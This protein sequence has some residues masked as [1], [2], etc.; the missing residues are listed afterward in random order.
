M[1]DLDFLD[2]WGKLEGFRTA[3]RANRSCCGSRFAQVLHD[4]LLAALDL[5]A[6]TCREGAKVQR[7]LRT[8]TDPAVR[9]SLEQTLGDCMGD[10]ESGG[11]GFYPWHL[12]DAVDPDPD[13]GCYYHP[14]ASMWCH[15]PI[16]D[17]MA[18]GDEHLCGLGP[19][20]RRIAAETGIRFTTYLCVAG[21]GPEGAGQL[22]PEVYETPVGNFRYR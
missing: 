2:L 11:C 4:R 9:A 8:E 20:I 12:L 10:F 3:V 16:P 18:V 22:D 19:I 14:V 5:L 21:I 6:D 1:S 7:R 13:F 17:W 15:G